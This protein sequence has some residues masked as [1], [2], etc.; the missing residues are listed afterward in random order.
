[1]RKT[2]L[3]LKKQVWVVLGLLVFL[4]L[5]ISIGIRIYHNMAERKTDEYKLSKIGYT[6]DDIKLLKNLPIDTYN[7]LFNSAKNDFLLNLLKEKYYLKANIEEYLNYAKIHPEYSPETIISYVNTHSNEEHYEYELSTDISKGNLILVNKYYSLS[8][9]YI[10]ETLVK[11]SRDYYYGTE[12]QLCKEA[13]EA[14]KKMWSEAQKEDI[15]L[16]INSS[17]RSYEEQKETYDNYKDKKGTTY[18]DTVAA[19]PGFSEHQTGLAIDIFSKKD[20]STKDF[21]NSQ[22]HIWLQNNAYK[23]GFIERYKEEKI[24]IT[25]FSAEPWHWRYVGI[26]A[27]TYIYEN[28]ITFDEYYAYFVE[29]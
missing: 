25:G 22:T 15:Y 5:S 13:Y 29:K 3:K 14:F 8:N 21:K 6:L 16:I 19:R 2:K 10:P 9:D 12:H 28:D 27:A 11:V 1:M 24:A 23:F 20:T 18:A 26:E 7:S 4:V 17:Y